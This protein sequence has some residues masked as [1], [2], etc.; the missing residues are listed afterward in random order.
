MPGAIGAKDEKDDPF[1][2]RMWLKIPGLVLICRKGGSGNCVGSPPL[3]ACLQ[4]EAVV[5]DDP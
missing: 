2:R 3:A 1:G 5:P 4:I